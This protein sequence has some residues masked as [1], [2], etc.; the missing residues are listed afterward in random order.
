VAIAGRFDCAIANQAPS[1]E[2]DMARKTVDLAEKDIQELAPAYPW[3]L[4]RFLGEG[5][6]KKE[7][8]CF[9]TGWKGDIQGVQLALLLPPATIEY[10]LSDISYVAQ[11]IY[12]TRNE[13][14]YSIALY[15][16]LP[17]ME[18]GEILAGQ[19][20]NIGKE[21]IHVG[22]SQTKVDRLVALGY[23]RLQELIA[24]RTKKTSEAQSAPPRRS[25]SETRKC[26]GTGK[27]KSL[28]SG[29]A[30]KVR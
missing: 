17:G 25:C 28:R 18:S 24:A 2:L 16:N 13:Q 22:D 8:A 20:L 14:G 5:S 15:V 9:F 30:D 1:G 11:W 4:I 26:G 7:N 21:R 10:S 12:W 3:T 27:T 19:T 6:E 23:R 29:R